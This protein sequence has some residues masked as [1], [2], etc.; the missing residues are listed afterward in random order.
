MDPDTLTLLKPISNLLV[1]IGIFLGILLTVYILKEVAPLITKKMKDTRKDN[2]GP[3]TLQYI[4]KQIQDLHDWHDQRDSDGG[5]AW[6]T[7]RSTQIAID[8][9]VEILQELKRSSEETQRTV[10]RIERKQNRGKP[11]S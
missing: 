4:A 9:L 2:T 11:Q 6:Y 5:F 7:R 8:K 3:Q 10:D 1:V